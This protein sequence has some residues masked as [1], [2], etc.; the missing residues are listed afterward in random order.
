MFQAK[1]SFQWFI[2]N[3]KCFANNRIIMHIYDENKIVNKIFNFVY[4]H[5]KNPPPPKKKRLK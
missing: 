2:M 5:Y 1:D 3:E 4:F